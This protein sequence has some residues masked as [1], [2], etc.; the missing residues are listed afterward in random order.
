MSVD[1]RPGFHRRTIEGYFETTSGRGRGPVVDFAVVTVGL[2]RGLGSWADVAG[3]EVLDLGCGTGELCWLACA[4]GATRVVGVN[5]SKG[6]LDYART[7]VDADFVQADLLAHLRETPSDSFDRIYALNVLEHMP[8]DMVVEVLEE[9]RRCLRDGGSLIAMVPNAT[10]AFGSMTRYWDIT[11]C[12]AFTP[13]SVNQLAAL[14]GFG[15]VDF[16]EWG[17]VPHGLLSTVRFALWQVIRGATWA[18]FMIE[19]ASNKGGIYTAD[20]LF[21]LKK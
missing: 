12:N 1:S 21:R 3:K 8:T 10:S 7:H 18:R 20:M 19:L 4:G 17:P 9:V 13:S 14:C 5:L 15:E 2:K 11:H 16:R 6:E